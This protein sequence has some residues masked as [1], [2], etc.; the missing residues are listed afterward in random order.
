MLH[1][2]DNQSIHSNLQNYVPNCRVFINYLH[3]VLQSKI[4]HFSVLLVLFAFRCETCIIVE[5]I[6][7]IYI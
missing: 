2:I 1:L 5:D 3:T 6:T 4:V 7:R